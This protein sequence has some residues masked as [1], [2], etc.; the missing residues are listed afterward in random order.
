MKIVSY[1][2]KFAFACAAGVVGFGAEASAQEWHVSPE[3]GTPAIL[4]DQDNDGPGNRMGTGQCDFLMSGN[5]AYSAALLVYQSGANAPYSAAQYGN[6]RWDILQSQGTL[7]DYQFS[8]K[9][10]NQCMNP[11]DPS[12]QESVS[13]DWVPLTADGWS[14]GW[15]EGLVCPEHAPQLVQAWCKTRVFW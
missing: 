4:P 13:S 1:A 5:Q 12:V 10:M 8:V 9:L 3:W 11:D 14:N 7:D 2:F 15:Y 6:G